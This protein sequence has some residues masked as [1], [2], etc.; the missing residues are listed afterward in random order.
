M[1][2]CRHCATF[3]LANYSEP[4]TVHLYRPFEVGSPL[5]MG[6]RHEQFRGHLLSPQALHA[7]R[8]VSWCA[9]STSTVEVRAE[10]KLV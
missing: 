4:R 10:D 8:L 2:F 5:L 7:A 9:H 1:D 6:I 3:I